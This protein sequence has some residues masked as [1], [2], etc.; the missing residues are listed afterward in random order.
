MMKFLLYLCVFLVLTGC[1]ST[2]SMIDTNYQKYWELISFIEKNNINFT[3]KSSIEW[4]S[5]NIPDTIFIDTNVSWAK[6]TKELIVSNL[7]DDQKQVI[8]LL[9][10]KMKELSLDRLVFYSTWFYGFRIEWTRRYGLYYASYGDPTKQS[11]NYIT[12]THISGN[13]YEEY[14]HDTWF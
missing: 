4:F 1:I 12:Y 9:K 6:V 5:L 8:A 11:D 13:W 10:E 2:Q 14:Y 7:N 3:Y